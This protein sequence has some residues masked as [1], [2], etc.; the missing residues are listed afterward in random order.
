MT[1]TFRLSL[2][3][4]I[5]LLSNTIYGQVTF[6]KLTGADAV[7]NSRVAGDQLGFSVAVSGDIAVVGAP[8]HDFDA[9]GGTNMGNAGAVYIFYR[10]EG[11]KD[12]WGLKKKLVASGNN[13]RDTG[14]NFGNAV[15]ISGNIIVVGAVFQD[16]NASGLSPFTDA[17]AAYVFYKDEGGADNWGLKEK[18][19]GTGN[20]GRQTED[21]FGISVAIS[22]NIIVVGAYQHDYAPG[23]GFVNFSGAA[24]VY[25]KD[26]GGAENWGL[27]KKLVG[28]G[29]NGRLEQ[30]NFGISLDISGDAIVVGAYLQDFNATGASSVN[31]AG[32]AY[33]FHKN[34]GGANNWGFV[35]KL[36]GSGT[37]SRTVGDN[38]GIAVAITGDVIVIGASQQDYNDKGDS[39]STGAGA[40]FVFYKNEGGA[41]NWGLKEKI[42]STGVNG[43][44][45]DDNFGNAVACA[46]DV[47]LVGVFGQDYDAAGATM[48]SNA[49]AA[50]AYNY[51]RI[52]ATSVKE[53][54]NVQ[55]IFVSSQNKNIHLSFSQA[56]DYTVSV[57]DIMGRKIHQSQ[58]IINGKTIERINLEGV[59]TGYYIVNISNLNTQ[60]TFKVFLK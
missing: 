20:N 35:K 27:K 52:N 60:Q 2:I 40:I 22:G 17:G 34:E 57:Y 30:D 50:I 8:L 21:N 48:V 44:M 6:K 23:T 33:V 29:S 39:L 42:A 47:I 43:R 18:L 12:N 54:Q 37:N 14:D 7:S 36:V 15:A 38:F 10:N 5:S 59:L 26:E 24:F 41:N 55:N 25:Y 28:G 32:A 45:G 13:G 56:G 53:Q 4:I 3:L 9:T 19:V 51:S 11:G 49:G 58:T 31:A 46:P 16:F 1:S